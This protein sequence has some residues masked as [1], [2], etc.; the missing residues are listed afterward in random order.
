MCSRRRRRRVLRCLDWMHLRKR[1]VRRQ[2]R[3]RPSARGWLLKMVWKLRRTEQRQRRRLGGWLEAAAGWMVVM[4]MGPCRR[5]LC[6]PGG[7]VGSAWRRLPI[8][9]ASAMRRALRWRA[10]SRASR[11]WP[12]PGAYMHARQKTTVGRATLASRAEIEAGTAETM[13]EAGGTPSMMDE[14]TGT[15]GT[16]AEAAAAAGV[17]TG[18]RRPL[19]AAVSATA[20][21]RTAAAT[22]ATRPAAP[23]T[24]AAATGITGRGRSRPTGTATEGGGSTIAGAAAGGRSASTAADRN[25]PGA[26]TGRRP[27]RCDAPA[28]R[29]NGR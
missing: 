5:L 6:R 27:R 22:T 4:V 20:E 28:M 21:T 10:T 14:G 24:A 19:A 11:R 15:T 23:N 3:G 2:R 12:R 8:R 9:A 16:R 18:A 7:S 25:H 1:S 17:R 26:A 29:T 13:T